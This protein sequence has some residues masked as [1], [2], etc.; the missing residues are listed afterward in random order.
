MELERI[1][2]QNL[3]ETLLISSA[4]LNCTNR[5]RTNSENIEETD[6]KGEINDIKSNDIQFHNH[7]HL[8]DHMTIG[9]Q[10]QMK[11]NTKVNEEVNEAREVNDIH[12]E[13][14][15]GID[16]TDSMSKINK[17]GNGA[18]EE[19]ILEVLPIPEIKTG[20]EAC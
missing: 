7:S 19:A 3:K 2:L 15:K 4:I 13:V 1:L 10:Y 16:S 8:S 14:N 18:C 12:E 5:I 11:R 17:E 20:I 9:E 6:K